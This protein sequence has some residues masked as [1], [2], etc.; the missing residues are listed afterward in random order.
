MFLVTEEEKKLNEIQ[1]IKEE[2]L[3]EKT[4]RWGETKKIHNQRIFADTKLKT[5][6]AQDLQIID[7]SSNNSIFINRFNNICNSFLFPL[8]VPSK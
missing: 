8:L 6:K 1:E 4:R 5:I 7:N 2:K 3:K